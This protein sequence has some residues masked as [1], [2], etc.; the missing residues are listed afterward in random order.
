MVYVVH[1]HRLLMGGRACSRRSVLRA[2]HSHSLR[3]H[4]G[5][6]HERAKLCAARWLHRC[7]YMRR[8]RLAYDSAVAGTFAA[9]TSSSTA[10]GYHSRARRMH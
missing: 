3:I 1:C 8:S 2:D 10:H 6:K 7:V 4:R 5:T 9:E